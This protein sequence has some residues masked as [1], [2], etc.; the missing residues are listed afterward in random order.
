M[1]GL[2]SGKPVFTEALLRQ[3][4]ECPSHG[5]MGQL[6]ESSQLH[7]VGTIIPNL[8]MGKLKFREIKRPSQGP[9][10]SEL[11]SLGWHPCLAACAFN[12]FSLSHF[13]A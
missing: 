12:H 10:A 6:L 11:Q 13:Q 7:E 5:F 3:C 2:I 8:E 4:A 9:P 1:A